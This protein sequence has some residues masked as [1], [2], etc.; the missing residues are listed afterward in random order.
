MCHV[1]F[2]HPPVMDTWVDVPEDQDAGWSPW[3]D[4]TV[5]SSQRPLGILKQNPLADNFCLFERPSVRPVTG[6]LWKRNRLLYHATWAACHDPQS[7]KVVCAQQQRIITWK[8]CS[9]YQ[10]QT[11][12]E[13]T[14]M[15][16]RVCAVICWPRKRRLRL[17]LQMVSTT[18]YADNTRKWTVAASRHSSTE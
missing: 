1:F 13:D 3:Q 12:S 9:C 7:H 14:R 11:G 2:I 4:L 16:H 6:P 5:K 8:W 15:L 17:T 18:W 10:V